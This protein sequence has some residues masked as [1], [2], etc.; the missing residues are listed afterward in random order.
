[1]IP[2]DRAQA[3]RTE[4]LISALGRETALLTELAEALARQRAAVARN[5]VTALEA[6]VAVAGRV[7]LTLQEAHRLRGE[8]L[9]AMGADRDHPLGHL[10]ATLP[11][12]L[13]GRVERSRAALAAAAAAATREATVNRSVLRS[14]LDAGD[15]Y[16]QALF[17]G[18]LP[19]PYTPGDGRPAPAGPAGVLV[20]KVA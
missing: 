3:Q 19:T 13:G 20:D 11:G 6:D 18:G 17:T 4:R 2:A 5:D 9:V 10:A 12:S 8:I 14:A 15:A 7:L 16:L 1:M